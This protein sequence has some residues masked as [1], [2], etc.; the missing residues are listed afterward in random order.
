MAIHIP[1]TDSPNWLLRAASK[2]EKDCHRKASYKYRAQIRELKNENDRLILKGETIIPTLQEEI[3][4]LKAEL[5]EKN[6]LCVA[7]QKKLVDYEMSPKGKDTSESSESEVENEDLDDKE[8]VELIENQILEGEKPG[9]VAITLPVDQEIDQKRES[10]LKEMTD[11]RCM[12]PTPLITRY[13]VSR[14]QQPPSSPKKRARSLSPPSAN[15]PPLVSS[16]LF[17]NPNPPAMIRT[18]DGPGQGV[19]RKRRKK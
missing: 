4:R 15:S 13:P 7:L 5:E 12:A 11:L 2:L 16:P 17:C 9:K 18:P 6:K 14:I 10:E 3:E 8:W 19:K 1:N